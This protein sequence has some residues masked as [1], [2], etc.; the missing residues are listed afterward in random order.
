MGLLL[1]K[2]VKASLDRDKVV[3]S[4]VVTALF[5]FLVILNIVLFTL[6]PRIVAPLAII[7]SN[8]ITVALMLFAVQP[9]STLI[10]NELGKKAQAMAEQV[11][12]ED[13]LRSRFEGGVLAD[14][15]PPDYETRVAIVKTKAQRLG[16]PLA[17]EAAVYIAQNIKANIRQI[18]GILKKIQAFI[19]LQGVGVVSMELV[20]Q[21]TKEIIDSE[22]AY[23][24]EYIIARIA[25]YYNIT[26]EEVVG[27]GKTTNVVNARQM[28]I[29]L[30]RKLTGLT[31]EQIGEAMNRDHSTVLHSIRKVEEL[32]KSDPTMAGVIRDITSNIT[33]NT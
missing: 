11:R 9:I 24:P 21:I 26:P 2:A 33:T 23:A 4:Y 10:Q 17:E 31:L 8:A 6:F 29:Y 16:I 1:K 3:K 19:D 28:A 15:Q 25:D 13:R 7:L 27:K 12:Q 5:A 22:K 14:I 30:I 32:L 20:Q 18:E